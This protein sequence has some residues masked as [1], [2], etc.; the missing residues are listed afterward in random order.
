MSLAK[1][2]LTMACSSERRAEFDMRR[3]VITEER[4]G[5][6]PHPLLLNSRSYEGVKNCRCCVKRGRIE[7]EGRDGRRARVKGAETRNG[8][9][10]RKRVLG[11]RRVDGGV[12]VLRE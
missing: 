12:M 6:C 10:R 5:S 7:S 4:T 3:Y 9:G 1:L 2:L 11:R 8:A